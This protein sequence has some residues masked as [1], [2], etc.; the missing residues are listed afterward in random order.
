L[1][2]HRL[3][4]GWST[5]SAFLIISSIATFS[6]GALR[7]KRSVRLE[8][9]AGITMVGTALIV[10]PWGTMSALGLVYLLTIPLSMWRYAGVK[11]RRARLAAGEPTL[12]LYPPLPPV[13]PAP[14]ARQ[15]RSPPD[16]P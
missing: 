5:L 13:P 4:A 10:A 2:D 15:R 14:A 7:L 16:A 6:M 12:P 11:R 3:V 8:A 9:V 1:R